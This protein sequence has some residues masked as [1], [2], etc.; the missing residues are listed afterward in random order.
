MTASGILKGRLALITG[1]GSGIGRA[2]CQLFASEGARIAAIDVQE[3]VHESVK[4]LQGKDHRTFVADVSST[5]AVEGLLADIMKHFSMPPCAVVNCAGITRDKMLVKMTETEFDEVISVNLKGTYI[6]SQ[7]ASKQMIASKIKHGSIVNI[8]SISGKVG[9]V[10]QCNYSAS[11]AGVVGFTKAAAKEL[12]RFNIRCNAVLPGFIDTPM[13]ESVPNKVMETVIASVPLGR[14]GKPSDI[15]DACL[16]LTSDR[17]SYITGACLE[18]T[19]G[20]FM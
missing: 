4:F 15:A 16:F 8:S 14:I 19:G 18:V 6:V 13:I 2:V 5:T 1:A 9:N 3:K 11:K 12:G 17:S 20:L 7:V 10:G